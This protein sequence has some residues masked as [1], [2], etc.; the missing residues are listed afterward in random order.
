MV[1]K[2][3]GRYKFVKKAFNYILIL[4]WT[5]LISSMIC[6]LTD[7]LPAS[8]QT[9]FL[10]P[11]ES[12]PLWLFLAIAAMMIVVAEHK[13]Y[14]RTWLQWVLRT[15]ATLSLCIGVFAAC[16]M[17]YRSQKN[18]EWISAAV[19]AV[20][21]VSAA[22]LFRKAY[23][24]LSIKK[25]TAVW[26]AA[27][28]IGAILGVTL[29]VPG[30]WGI[31][32]LSAE[33]PGSPLDYYMGQLSLTFIT[34]SVMSMLSDKS[35]IIYWENVAEAKLIKPLFGSF[36]AYTAYS[37]T[38][39]VGAGISVLLDN[40]TAFIVFL[41]I[42]VIIMIL[43][44]LT[45]VDVY[46]GR[47]QKRRQLAHKL[48]FAARMRKMPEFFFSDDLAF[49][50]SMDYRDMMQNLH[51]YL[52][53]EI[54]ERNIPYIREVAEL[55]GGYMNC[56]AT[57]EGEEVKALLFSAPI[58]LDRMIL[59]GLSARVSELT[60]KHDSENAYASMSWCED[61]LCWAE[62]AEP[63][64]LDH[65]TKDPALLDKLA[66]IVLDRT[67]LMF[68][69]LLLSKGQS[70]GWRYHI[71]KSFRRYRSRASHELF[72][73]LLAVSVPDNELVSSLSRVIVHLMKNGSDGTRL[74]LSVHPAVKAL[75]GVIDDVE[76]NFTSSE[77]WKTYF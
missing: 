20:L 3:H 74:F 55:Y 76:P 30:A 40:D 53:R 22:A 13:M 65:L 77:L 46:Y 45:M 52:Y 35:V 59:D 11:D 31:V 21:F 42:N 36:A 41:S 34:I 56:F 2:A 75:E 70:Y 9:A 44:T 27:T 54:G 37:V 32:P 47:D 23:R 71:T 26:E 73:S 67:S 15:I 33:L 48:Q 17:L 66:E 6:A 18:L 49:Y 50:K 43:L 24:R 14:K 19:M 4:N 57:K 25:I 61:G 29:W 7:R 62:I 1:L 72:R 10:S 69:D 16:N 51:H 64:N 39:T 60:R 68:N 12:G 28:L 38:A 5:W 63:E 58:E 8:V